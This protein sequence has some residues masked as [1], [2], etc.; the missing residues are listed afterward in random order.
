MSTLSNAKLSTSVCDL[1]HARR[2]TRAARYPRAFDTR[3][4]L[5]VDCA[6]TAQCLIWDVSVRRSS[7]ASRGRARVRLDFKDDEEGM[8]L[9]P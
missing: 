1:T 5:L 7:Q 9:A 2:R 3:L 6:G 8:P 4:F